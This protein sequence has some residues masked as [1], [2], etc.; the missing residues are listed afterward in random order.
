MIRLTLR[1]VLCAAALSAVF[2]VSLPAAADV[3]D[4]GVKMLEQK[5]YAEAMKLFQ[6]EAK[7]DN[8]KAMYYVGDM[9]NQGLGTR[10]QPLS[11]TSWW[12]RCAYLGDAG[13]QIALAAAYR[14]GTGVRVEPRQALIW[15]RKAA[16]QG[17]PVAMKNVGDYFAQGNGQ[18]V[19]FKEA[20]KWYWQG[21]RGGY[22]DALQALGTLLKNGEGVEK[23]EVYALVL[24]REAA[25]P[26]KNYAADR[27]A[28]ADA[29]VISHDLSKEELERADKLSAAEVLEALKAIG[30]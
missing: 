2:S 16:K 6:A 24:M 7:K 23:N 5:R 12:E 18:E 15:D 11:A 14:N 3:I 10:R 8:P 22:P 30:G 26:Q 28:A 20:A 1:P 29:R 9:L 27:N 13:C 19:D 25:K 21:A 4:D 17:N